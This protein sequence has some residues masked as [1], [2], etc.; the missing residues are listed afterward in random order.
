MLHPGQQL[1]EQLKGWLHEHQLMQQ[2]VLFQGQQLLQIHIY[3]S[4][5]PLP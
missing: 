2:W 3:Q 1:D 5:N 4:L